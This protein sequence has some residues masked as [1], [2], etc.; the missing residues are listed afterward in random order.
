LVLCDTSTAKPRTT[1]MTARSSAIHHI[2]VAGWQVPAY[3]VTNRQ[4]SSLSGDGAAGVGGY[5][6]AMAIHDRVAGM[7][8]GP[9]M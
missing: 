5:V 1:A 6:G 4:T 7:S 2:R 3:R 8:R 9:S